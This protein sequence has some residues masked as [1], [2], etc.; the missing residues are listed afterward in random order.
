[1][2]ANLM[3]RSAL[4]DESPNY[5]KWHLI[6]S[7]NHFL[8]LANFLFENEKL[9]L[10]ASYFLPSSLFIKLFILIIYKN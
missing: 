6:S 5:E 9:V 4:Q 7:T 8:Y 3:I 1:M 10:L 2:H